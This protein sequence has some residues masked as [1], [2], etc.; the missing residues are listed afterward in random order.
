LEAHE[1]SGNLDIHLNKTKNLSLAAVTI[2]KPGGRKLGT[3]RSQ[4]L[5]I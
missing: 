4:S 1:D 2:E 3:N 5:F